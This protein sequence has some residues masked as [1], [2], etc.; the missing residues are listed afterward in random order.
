MRIQ[1]LTWM[2]MLVAIAV[3]GSMFISIPTGVARAYPIQHMVNVIA[4]V[5]VGPIGAVL[6]AF[7]TGLIRVITG[8][9]SLLAFPGGMI[10]AFLAGIF[11]VRTNRVYAAALGEIIGTGVIASLIAVPYA[12][13]LMGST[14]GA[15]F[16]VPAFLASSLTGALLGWLVLSRVKQLRP[17]VLK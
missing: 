5:T 11:F 16:F 10:G 3:V 6:V 12:K 13:L 7:V 14:F 8:T 1:Q 15:F 4:A 9:G 17:S 2:A